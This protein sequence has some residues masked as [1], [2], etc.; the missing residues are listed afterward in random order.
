MM[1]SL[2]FL[3]PAIAKAAVESQLPRGY[4]VSRFADLPMAFADQWSVPGLIRAA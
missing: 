2:A 1:L 4:G 3:D